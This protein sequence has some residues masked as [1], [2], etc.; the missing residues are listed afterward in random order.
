MRKFTLFI[1]SLF[2]TIGTVWASTPL[3]VGEPTTELTNGNY[4]LMAMSD[5]GTGPCY[6]DAAASERKYRYNLDK[7]VTVGQEIESQYVWTV[8]VTTQNGKKFITV[9][10][11]DNADVFFPADEDKNKNF[12]G[13]AK[14]S[15]IP[16]VKT[17]GGVNY[18]VLTLE[19]TNIGY[20]HANKAANLPPNL[21]YWNAYGDGGSC[22]KFTFYPIEEEEVVLSREEYIAA[23]GDAIEEASVLVA[24]ANDAIGYYSS[25]M[26]DVD[27]V[28][29]SV[30]AFKDNISNDTTDEQ[31]KE[32]LDKAEEVVE[33]FS[34]NEP[35]PGNYYRFVGKF[36]GKY[37]DADALSGDKLGMTA[38]STGDG[39]L[40]YLTEGYKLRS[41]SLDTYLKDTYSINGSESNANVLTFHESK[42][43]HKGYFT[44]TTNASKIGTFLYDHG[45]KGYVDRNSEYADTRCDWQIIEVPLYVLNVGA[46]AMVGASATWNGETKKLPAAWTVIAGTTIDDATLSVSHNG[47]FA[48]NGFFEGE[49]EL[50]NT[51]EIATLNNQRNITARFSLDI[52]SEKYGD[53]WTTITRADGAAHAITLTSKDVDTKPIFKT[54]DYAN[55]GILWC[56]VGTP[57]SF[58]IYNKV[59]GDALALTP[60]TTPGNGVE[61]KMVAT[62]DAQSW[63]LI[64]KDRGYAIAP[65]NSKDWGINSYGGANSLGNPVKFYG[66]DDSGTWWNFNL[67]DL[68]KPLIFSVEVDKVWESSPRVAEL[69]FG[70]NGVN[71]QTRITDNVEGA[72]YYLPADATFTLSSMTYRGYTFNGF[73]DAEGKPADE[74]AYTDAEIIEGGLTLGASYTANDERTLYYSPGT[75]GKPYRIPAIATAPNG[76]IFAIADYRPCGSDIGYGEVDVMCRISTDNGTTWS[77]EFFVADGKGG[78][79]NEM[80]TGF[81][82]AAIV[83]DRDQNKLLVMMV[84]GRTVCHNGRWDKSKIGDADA[85]EVNRVARRYAEYNETTGE[86]EWSEIVE[87]T[88]HIYP[89]F[90]DA[91][92]NATVTSMFIG[93]GKICQSRVV[94]KGDYY[95]LYCAMWTRDGGN[96]VIYS[97]DFGGSW[98]VLGTITD[99]PAPRGDEPKCEELPDGTV[100]LSSRVSGGR[101]F[102]LFTFSDDT[103]TAGTWGT[104]VK[105]SSAYDGSANGTNGE[106]YKVKA[107]R[108]SDN[109]ICDVMLQ[110]VPAGPGRTNVKV[111][112]KEMDYSNAYTPTTFAE[113]W[114]VG[115]HVSDKNSCYSTMIMQADGRIG[116]LFEEEPNGYC[117]VYIPYTLEDLTGG[118]YALYKEAGSD[119]TAIDNISATN[120]TVV[121]DLLGRCVQNV[122]KGVYIVNG[123]KVVIK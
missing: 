61:I 56:F 63:C 48:F 50:G 5:K 21:S 24:E 74:T 11:Y 73:L 87:M 35:R 76:H 67:M 29:A 39:S 71:S 116:F 69:T 57:E 114:T 99:R 60:S 112:Y 102:N 16:E 53:K 27:D 41:V 23:L 38:N 82:D 105:S 66:V 101:F 40:F 47:T 59:S 83:A 51:V 75:T 84:C 110:S 72:T 52:V 106:I 120:A 122:E 79:T 15:L 62:A 34:L 18:I 49:T 64:E 31:I 22:V 97:D 91:N 118:K 108:K 92:D 95:R 80:T 10:N 4:V 113:G 88:D 42:G 115:K 96:R 93:S 77:D 6:Y 100:V 28:L 121:Y 90:H 9:T 109:K 19:D 55:E 30:V 123:R 32:Q 8:K 46:P 33:S 65:V 89:L 44:I 13:A 85:T 70:I 111:Y 7:T 94:K 25:Y 78:N 86:W 36:S 119:D 14:A 98:N 104:A 12:A 3:K 107:V 103:Y 26:E 81:G 117:I 17:I 68:T 20:I 45:D 1:A 37:I 43:G 54:I 58:K 2:L